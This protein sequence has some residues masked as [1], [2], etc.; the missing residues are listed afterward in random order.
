M[1]ERLYYRDPALTEFEATIT[2]SAVEKGKY[3]TVLDRSAFYPTSGGQQHDLGILN[4]V[5]VVDVVDAGDTVRH[6]TEK[7]VG[8]VGQTVRGEV[9]S[10]RRRRH[11]QQH[12]A[13]HILSQT[14]I[15]LYGYETVSVHL[16]DEYGAIELSVPSVELNHVAEV[17]RQANEIV[18]SSWPVE[19]LF[20]SGAEIESV[21]LRKIP[22]REGSL[23]V[24][25]IGEFDWSACG[26]THCNS[27][28]EVGLIKI[29]GAEKM[30]GR[31]LVNFLAG[32]QALEDYRLRFDVTDSLS[33]TFTC[34]VSD[35]PA[36]TG[37]L[38]DENKGLRR[39]ITMLQKEL[40]PIR[41]KA[42]AGGAE[43]VGQ[44]RTIA[45]EMQGMDAA[46]AGQLGAV[47]ADEIDGL[48]LLA[49]EGK[50]LISVG[51]T[52]N[53]HA[54]ELAK[55]LAAETGLRGGGS[56]RA[57]QLGGADTS[58]LDHYRAILLSLIGH[59]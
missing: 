4:G 39:E 26:G 28:A 38:S 5:P 51:A 45:R 56:N 47:V 57:A 3:H 52:S 17:E 50:L 58:K 1:T 23:R 44:V 9:D 55:K 37:K 35:L 18:M 25:K 54:G 41:A 22:T 19:I 49:A 32:V 30:R 48:V 53:L 6:V 34:H 2:E 59:V 21:P 16:G 10:A 27:T 12:T 24:I 20:L 36:K 33:R 7:S 43:T 42:L 15:R 29:I 8:E 14:F 31:A 46:S 11:R 40:I 13:Q